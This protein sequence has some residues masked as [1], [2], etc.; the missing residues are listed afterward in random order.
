MKPAHIF[1]PTEHW[2]AA[3]RVFQITCT[4]TGGQFSTV[5][6]LKGTQKNQI[7]PCCNERVKHSTKSGRKTKK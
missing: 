4:K 3:K 2:A 1:K 5:M 6:W 7:C